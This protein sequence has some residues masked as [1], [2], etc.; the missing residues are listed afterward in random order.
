MVSYLVAG[1]DGMAAHSTES[2][3]GR[4]A[5]GAGTDGLVQA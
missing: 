5:A 4:A 2:T 1:P 3:I